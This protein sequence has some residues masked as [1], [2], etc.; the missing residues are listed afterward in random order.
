MHHITL[1]LQ[2]LANFMAHGKDDGA[3]LDA[4]IGRDTRAARVHHLH[5]QVGLLLPRGVVV[6]KGNRRE[7]T[8]RHIRFVVRYGTNRKWQN[9]STMSAFGS[10]PDGICSLRAF[11]LLTHSGHKR[12]EIPQ[13]NGC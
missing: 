8:N 9:A 7:T 2:L 11:P 6:G 1:K 4:A 10:N 12:L 3:D 5:A 13:C